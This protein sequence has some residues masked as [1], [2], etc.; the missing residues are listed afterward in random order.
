MKAGKLIAL[1]HHEKWDGTG[2]PAGL[3]GKD[4]HPYGRIAI[5]V[6][7]FDA[8][9]SDRPYKKAMSVEE[10]VLILEDGRGGFFD[11]ELLDIFLDNIEVFRKIK[12]EFLD[13]YEGESRQES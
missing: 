13:I 6:D 3:S 10:A 9:T 5:I 2:Y 4:I 12:D 8:L 11:P 1:Q 7:I